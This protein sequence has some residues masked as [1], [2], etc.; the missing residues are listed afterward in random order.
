MKKLSLLIAALLGISIMSYADTWVSMSKFKDETFQK[1]LSTV[2]KSY[3][4]PDGESINVEQIYCVAITSMDNYGAIATLEGIK[5]LINLRVLY[6][7]GK[8]SSNKSS[9]L[10]SIDVSGMRYLEIIDN[11]SKVNYSI[12]SITHEPSNS[13]ATY[14]GKSN[15][16][17]K[18]VSVVAENCTKLRYVA[19]AGWKNLKTVSL[20]GSE[21]VESLFLGYND[22]METLDVSQLPNLT[23][24][25]KTTSSAVLPGSFTSPGYVDNCYA[26]ASTNKTN[27][28]VPNFGISSMSA[29]KTLIIGNHPDWKGFSAQQDKVLEGVNLAGCPNLEA[30]DIMG[31]STVAS[32][33]KESRRGATLLNKLVLPE[34]L[35]YCKYFRVQQTSVKNLDL[36]ALYD[37]ALTVIVQ[38]NYITDFPI[39][40]FKKATTIYLR[41]NCLYHISQPNSIVN[42]F[43]FAENR[44]TE[45]PCPNV[46]P[47][48]TWG[49]NPA[50]YNPQR[51]NVPEGTKAYKITDNPDFHNHIMYETGG[52]T[53]TKPAYYA[54][55]GGHIGVEADGEDPCYFYFDYPDAD[56]VYYFHYAM[57]KDQESKSYT[58]VTLHHGYDQVDYGYY[59]PEQGG[60][61]KETET[62]YNGMG[63]LGLGHNITWVSGGV[64]PIDDITQT[65]K[66]KDFVPEVHTIDAPGLI[67][68]TS[69]TL[70]VDRGDVN[71]SLVVNLRPD[72][73]TAKRSA[74]V[75]LEL[76]NPETG[77]FTTMT[78]NGDPV[79]YQITP[80]AATRTTAVQN[81]T[82]GLAAGT[83]EGHIDDLQWHDGATKSSRFAF[84]LG[85]T[86]YGYAGKSTEQNAARIVTYVCDSAEGADYDT[87]VRIAGGK[88]L[89]GDD[90]MYR[91][92]QPV[93][94][95]QSATGVDDIS[96][97]ADAGDAGSVYYDIRG[98][99]IDSNN[100]QPGLYLKVTGKKVEKV[101][102][103]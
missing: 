58:Q 90:Y 75:T 17:P 62:H 35:P 44:L 12:N 46:K 11:G 49:S 61:V 83:A 4:S 94:L 96:I 95:S 21:A 9:S 45:L 79:F 53:K 7:P 84:H 48:M 60:L 68:N 14:D 42:N 6:L 82:T 19:I 33:G 69:S 64:H 1:Y 70:L 67:Y 87:A 40:S 97:D 89:A 3:L 100:L 20:K 85:K 13:T 51:R 43:L 66:V 102:I 103:R 36:S 54:V 63:H 29:L 47:S 41:N 56:G 78:A 74:I 50:D 24:T 8:V 99:R 38:A 31:N 18:L 16:A 101:H 55:T 92:I 37:N 98:M 39:N 65:V 81:P 80:A 32:T 52:G 30:I 86:L 27:V 25:L 93:G 2:Y 88:G 23:N 72:H 34:A 91:V 59:S 73:I 10:K 22:A 76:A 15:M 71:I 26:K 77:E 5:E 57:N 28:V